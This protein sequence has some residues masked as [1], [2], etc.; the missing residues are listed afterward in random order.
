MSS[1]FSCDIIGGCCSS[2]HADK[3]YGFKS[4]GRGV[5]KVLQRKGLHDSIAW[6][7][8]EGACLLDSRHSNTLC[9][10][11]GESEERGQALCLN[12]LGQVVLGKQ[13]RV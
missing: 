8:S 6:S 4:V 9:S 11:I 7:K 1:R 3:A 13:Q 10:F 12:L 5:F 2:N